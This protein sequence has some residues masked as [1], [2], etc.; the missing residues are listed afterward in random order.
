MDATVLVVV[1]LG[2]GDIL[3]EERKEF[4]RSC[5]TFRGFLRSSPLCQ[6]GLGCVVRGEL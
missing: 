2:L 4:V 6:R 3:L 1:R 5:S